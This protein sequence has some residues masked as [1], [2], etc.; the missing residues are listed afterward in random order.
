MWAQPTD[1]FYNNARRED[2]IIL[3]S[4]VVRLT[5]FQFPAVIGLQIKAFQN[6]DIL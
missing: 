6:A 5:K 1:Y 4:S 3:T 2:G